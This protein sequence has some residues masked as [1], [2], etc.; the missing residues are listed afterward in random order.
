MKYIIAGLLICLSTTNLFSQSAD[1]I[2]SAKKNERIQ[3]RYIHP[4]SKYISVS[5]GFAF[6]S[7]YTKDPN[8]FLKTGPVMMNNHYFPNIKYE[9]GVGNNFFIETGYEFGRIGINMGREMKEDEYW[10]EYSR[11]V[12]DHNNH[13][14][15]FG[16]GYRVIGKNNFHFLNIHAG[17]FL[18]FSNKNQSDM[19][20]FMNGSATYDIEEYPTGLDY[21][22]ERTIKTYSRFS[23]GPY[24]GLSHEFRL[25]SDVRFIIKYVQRFGLNPNFSGTYSFSDNLNFEQSA[26]FQVRGGGAFISGGLKILLFK[27]KLDK[28]ES[29]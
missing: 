14:F 26:T 23:F 18:G 11:M 12:H 6:T 4:K 9:H 7:T 21:Q 22:I 28:N 20:N 29:Y 19:K 25:S 3:K 8:N 13:I 2:K 24:I 5:A 1:S 17:I 15:L 16:G 10:D 27:G